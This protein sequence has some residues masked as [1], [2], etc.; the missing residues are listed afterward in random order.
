METLTNI[1]VDKNLHR[2]LKYLSIDMQKPLREVVRFLIDRNKTLEMEVKSLQNQ[3][4]KKEI[5]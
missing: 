4:N 2:Q 5:A 1:A 3:I